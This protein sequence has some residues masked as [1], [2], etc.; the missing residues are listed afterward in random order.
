[1]EKGPSL[2]RYMSK[3]VW[4]YIGGLVCLL[5]VD[6][7]ELYIPQLTGAITDGLTAGGFTGKMLLTDVALIVVI[8]TVVSLMRFGG[9][10][11]TKSSPP[12]PTGFSR[13]T[14]PAT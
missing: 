10:T 14:R 9:R 13:A 12:S 1:M 3:Y 2:L 8:A 11:Y 5:S 7:L 4:Q 6:F